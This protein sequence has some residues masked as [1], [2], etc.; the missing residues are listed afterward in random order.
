MTRMALLHRQL[1]DLLAKRGDEFN[2]ADNP[3]DAESLYYQSLSLRPNNPSLLRK[4]GDIYSKK[5]AVDDAR[6]C[7]LGVIPDSA[8]ERFFDSQQIHHRIINVRES[9]STTTYA[10]TKAEHQ[11]LSKPHAHGLAGNYN[12][13]NRTQTDCRGGM[14]TESLCGELWFDG[15]NVIAL[16]MNRNVLNEHTKGNLHL[17]WRAASARQP[18]HINGRVCFLDA[19]SSNIYYH[20]MLDVLPKI[21]LLSLAGITL[22]SI[23]KFIV[24]ASSGFQ[25]DT[26]HKLG[27]PTDKLIFQDSGAHYTADTLI[28]PFLKND[29]GDRVY[30]GLGL[31]LAAWVPEFL[32]RSFLSDEYL[33]KQSPLQSLQA[34]A[35]CGRRLYISRAEA[36]SRRIVNE[37]KIKSILN[38]FGFEVC[39]FESMSVSE[40]AQQMAEAEVVVACHGAGLTNLAFC[41]ENTRVLEIFGE[42][43]VPCYWSLSNLTGLEYHFFMANSADRTEG[44]TKLEPGANNVVERR[45]KDLR[46]DEEQFFKALSRLCH[47]PA[48]VDHSQVAGV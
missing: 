3:D 35:D 43:I 1:A 14:V 2:A 45:S 40:Q 44:S 32:K 24:R 5:N 25:K 47:E 36:G 13:F 21:H 12:Q 42:Y 9:E 7:Y 41:R 15:L 27:I 46:I 29:L 37:D 11:P 22:D 48:E 6:M 10:V 8:N 38:Q 19:R 30:T 33:L 16:D 28:M 31:G 17:A 4:L 34:S 23:D 18:E 20:W 26:L 39:Q